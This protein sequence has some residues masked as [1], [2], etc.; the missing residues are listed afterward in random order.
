MS[1]SSG[2]WRGVDA[3]ITLV[4]TFIIVAFVAFCGVMGDQAGAIFG[5]LSTSI[6]LNFKW[7]Y[8]AMA[9]GVLVYLLYLMMSRYGNITLGRDGEKPEFSTTSWLSMLFSAGMGI[10]LLFWS[11]AEP[12]WHYAGNPFSATALTDEAAESAMRVTFFHWGMHAWALYLMPALCLAYFS[13]RKGKPLSIRSTLVP[14]FG[15]ARMN[16]WLGAIFDILIVVVT[17][18]G[19]ATSFGLGVEQMTTGI[20]TLTGYEAG[21]GVKMLLILSISLIAIMS[22]VSGVDRGIKL[23]SLWNMAL[24]LLILAA[25]MAFG[26]TRYILNTILEGTSG[27]AQSVIGMSLWSDAQ[28][29][30]GWQNWWTAF[31]WAWWLTWA[32]FVGTFIARISR[33]RTI[34]QLVMGSLIIPVL[35]SFVWIGTFGGAALNYEKAD[36]VAHQAQVES[37]ALQGEAAEFKGGEVLL[38]TKADATNSLFTLFDKIEQSAGVGIGGLLSALASLL[39]VTYFVTSADSGTLVVSTL[40][41]RGSLNPPTASRVAWGLMVGAIAAGLLWSGGLKSVQTASI[42]AALPIAVIL[43]LMAMALHRTLLAEPAKS[44]TLNSADDYEPTLG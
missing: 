24:S 4:S 14:L 37:Q 25:V 8:L 12:M 17:A 39:I 34:R 16:G 28:K 3:R 19:I 22:V 11:V 35:F 9:S 30:A 44:L 15:E 18:F 21:I 32:P 20:K 23:L 2:L 13:F 26:P 42:C 27:Y 6:L 36:R 1:N 7:F 10:G 38:A 29:D 33:G 40:A 5:E 41:A 31:Y 43:I